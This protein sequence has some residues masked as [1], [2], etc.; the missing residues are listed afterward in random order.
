MVLVVLPLL[1]LLESRGVN[2]DEGMDK[3]CD[4]ASADDET[5]AAKRYE[6]FT[7]WCAPFRLVGTEWYRGTR[8]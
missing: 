8:Y 1:P 6:Y 4:C 3:N 2:A 7:H 5:S